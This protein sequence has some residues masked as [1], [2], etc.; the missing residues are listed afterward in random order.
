MVLCVCLPMP[1]FCSSCPDGPT[2]T[3][4]PQELDEVLCF[5]YFFVCW[6]ILVYK[7]TVFLQSLFIYMTLALHTFRVGLNYCVK[8]IDFV[9]RL[10]L[11]HVKWLRRMFR[12]R[13]SV[14][15]QPC[16]RVAWVGS[17]LPA[18]RMKASDSWQRLRQRG[19]SGWGGA[20]W[21]RPSDGNLRQVG[22]ELLV[23]LPAPSCLVL[24]MK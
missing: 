19:S 21:D 23:L 17:K 13:V 20:K 2:A 15:K 14:W 18:S 16:M 10:C 24:R 5:G 12:S 22:T 9:F 11:H 7:I 1:F 4:Q 8:W 3:P 6:V